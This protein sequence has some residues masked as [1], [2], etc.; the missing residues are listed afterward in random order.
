[1]PGH[2]LGGSP[3]QGCIVIGTAPQSFVVTAHAFGEFEGKRDR[4]SMGTR[5]WGDLSVGSFG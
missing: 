2:P 3:D 5:A 1:V 4:D